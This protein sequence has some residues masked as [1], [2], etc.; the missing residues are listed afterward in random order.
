MYHQLVS[1]QATPAATHS[2]YASEWDATAD[3]DVFT[4][5]W[6]ISISHPAA[7]GHRENMFEAIKANTITGQ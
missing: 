7:G 2:P 1:V 5:Y 4:E 6:I 3:V